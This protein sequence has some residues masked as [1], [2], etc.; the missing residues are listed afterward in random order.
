MELG[1]IGWEDVLDNE[2]SV[3]VIFL[4]SQKLLVPQEE[5]NSIEL[6]S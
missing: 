4:V 2:A 3:S 5:L 1:K 6:V